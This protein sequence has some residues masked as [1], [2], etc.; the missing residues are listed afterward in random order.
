MYGIH[1]CHQRIMKKEELFYRP[2][3]RGRQGPGG[4]QGQS[5]FAPRPKTI[6]RHSWRQFLASPAFDCLFGWF[7][8][9]LVNH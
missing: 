7:L 5:P 8:N 9:V 2:G 6:F 3:K 4:V 1:S